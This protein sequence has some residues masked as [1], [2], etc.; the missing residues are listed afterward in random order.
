MICIVYHNLKKIH[1]KKKRRKVSKKQKPGKWWGGVPEISQYRPEHRQEDPRKGVSKMEL[2]HQLTGIQ[3][4]LREA[5]RAEGPEEKHRKN[6]ANEK[7][8][9][10]D[11][12]ENRKLCKNEVNEE[13]RG[14]AGSHI[15]GAPFQV[16]DNHTK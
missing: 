3:L 16:W 9:Q 1:I 7:R 10:W 13:F 6:Q 8:G 14:S 12:Q 15:T 2:T 5:W 11:C 4:W